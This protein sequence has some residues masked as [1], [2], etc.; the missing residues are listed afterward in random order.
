MSATSIYFNGRLIREPGSYSEVDA[1]GLET[2]GLGASGIVAVIGTAVGGKPYSAVGAKDIKDNLETAISDSQGRAY[3]RS[4]DLKEVTPMLFSP[5]NDPEIQGG[6]AEVVYVKANPSA[7]SSAAF[8]NADGEAIVLTS[9]DYGFHTTQ[10]KTTIGSGTNQGKLVTLVFEEQTEALDDVGGDNVFTLQYL[11]S[12]PADGYTTLTATVSSTALSAAFTRAQTGLDGDVSN[13]VTAGQVIELV[14]SAAGDTAIVVEI[15]GTD[16]S[17]AAQRELVTCNGTTA[18]DTTGVWNSFHGARIISGTAAG[19]ITLRNDGAGTTITTLTAGSPTSGLEPCVDMAAYSTLSYVAGGASTDR[20]T[21]I[22]L[23]AAG[24]IQVETVQLNGTT[25]VAG[26]L[27]WSRLDY[28]SLGELAAATTLTVSGTAVYAPFAG[29]DTVQ[30]AADLFNSKSGF[31]FTLITG[32]TAFL[33]ENLD[34]DA[35]ATAAQILKSAEVTSGQVI[36]MV[37]S[38][39]GDTAVVLEIVGLSAAGALQIEQVTLNGTTAVDTTLTYAEFLGARVVSGSATGTITVR[40]DGAGTTITTIA[41]GKMSGCFRADLYDMIATIN[42]ESGLVTAARGSVGTGA[43]DNT[44]ADVFLTGGNEG[45]STPGQ[46]GVPTATTTNWQACFDLLK[47]VFVNSIAVLSADPAVAAMAKSHCEYMAGRGKMERDTAVGLKNAALTGL[48]TKTEIKVQII[49]LNSRHVR[50]WAQKIERYNTDGDAEQFDPQFGA[51]LLLAAQAGS[52]VGTSLTRK[53]INTLSLEQDSSWDP[54]DDVETM[55]AYGLCFGRADDNVGRRVVRNVTTHLSTS[56]L[57]FV[58][59]SVN[60]AINYAV[61]NYRTQL[62]TAVGKSGFLGTINAAKAEAISILGQLVDVALT[63]YRSL[64]MELNLDVLTSSV[65][66]AP[67][68][69]INFVKT[70]VHVVAVPQSASAA[71]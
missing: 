10:I 23:S 53:V 16:A 18:V 59:A 33:M 50:A 1:S 48:A 65:E 63:A 64:S 21:V 4:G 15:T 35:I 49:N 30:K 61:Y 29:I 25:P 55:I 47:K 39:A 7:Q 38:A 45:S 46:E 70:T 12:T 43:P 13:Q 67:V 66:M 34:Y 19:T 28:L 32:N 2:V 22:G 58:E 24:A 6:A 54:T 11:A 60:E 57:A 9:I 69:P 71:A 52:P 44:T 41:S 40:N 68:I 14:S 27:S 56:N 26:T 8:D 3:F 42:A 20:V 62:E 5:F 17:D 37:S 36:E 51:A 31:T